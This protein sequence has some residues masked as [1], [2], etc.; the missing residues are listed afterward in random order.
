MLLTDPET[1]DIVDANP[2][3]VSFYGYSKEELTAKKITEINTLPLE[4]IR[5]VM[6]RAC[7]GEEQHFFFQHR[8]ADGTVRDV[9]VFSGPITVKGK[10]LLY[11]IVHDITER[12]QAEEELH[13]SYQR[14]DLLAGTAGELLASAAPQRVID[15]LC[16]K[17]DGFSAGRGLLKFPGGRRGQIPDFEC[18]RG[19]GDEEAD[20]IRWLKFGQGICGYTA[21][22]RRRRWRK[23][24]RRAPTR[25]CRC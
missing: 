11:S 10:K 20:R 22:K 12:R 13:R 4:R 24:F 2:A 16:V 25:R 8:L 3:A 21:L 14:L 6:K 23:I 19:I 1:A 9:E 5:E 18:L 15:N 17:A 7:S